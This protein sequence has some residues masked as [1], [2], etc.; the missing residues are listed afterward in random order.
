MRS[1][2]FSNASYV[3]ECYPCPG[4]GLYELLPNVPNIR[5]AVAEAFTVDPA[6][7]ER[8]ERIAAEEPRVHVLRGSQIQGQQ[9]QIA[10]YLTGQGFTAEVPAEN[11]GVA[12]RTDY[13]QTVVRVYNGADE[14]K[15]ESYKALTGYFGTTVERLQ[16][17]EDGPDFVVVTG[18]LTPNLTPAP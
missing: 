11:G 10:A 5:R 9:T 17:P 13:L 1:V 4:T 16:G 7:E 2:V 8:R 12:D 18:G 3:T 6:I 15:P 14:Q